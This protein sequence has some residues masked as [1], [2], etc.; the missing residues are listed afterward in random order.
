MTHKKLQYFDVRRKHRVDKNGDPEVY[1]QELSIN[2]MCFLLRDITYTELYGTPIEPTST[3]RKNVF[4]KLILNAKGLPEDL[5]VDA[6]GDAVTN[7]INIFTTSNGSGAFDICQDAISDYTHALTLGDLF[8]QPRDTS[9]NPLPPLA[10]AR[11]RIVDAL[12]HVTSRPEMRH[13]CAP[14]VGIQLGFAPLLTEFHVRDFLHYFGTKNIEYF[15]TT[16][17]TREERNAARRA[18]DAGILNQK[19]SLSVAATGKDFE[20]NVLH[21][22]NGMICSGNGCIP[23]GDP[24]TWCV[25]VI[26]NGTRQCAL[27]SDH[28]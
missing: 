26:V 21:E 16:A 1:P 14:F 12:D 28:A 13:F 8:W 20:A 15:Y 18:R 5:K 22:G 10:V 24:S 17:G 4:D 6:A 9:T 2:L 3:S 19:R 11:N 25:E 27:G 7:F 23:S